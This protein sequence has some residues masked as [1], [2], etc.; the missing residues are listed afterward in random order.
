MKIILASGSP[1]RKELLKLIIPEFEVIVSGLDEK[2]DQKLSIQE[3]SKALA[4]IKAKEVFDRTEGDR[5]VIGSDTIV[6]KNEKIYGK[7]KSREDAKNML[8]ELIQGDS[9]HNIYTSLAIIVSKNGEIK[10]FNCVDEVK[11]FLKKM[12]DEEIEKWL[13]LNK[14]QGKAGAYG[15][16]DEFC[17]YVEKIEGNYTSV[18]GLPTHR[19]YD[20]LSKIRK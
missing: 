16:Q 10:E 7:A 14:W 12:T 19:V 18:V 1:R 2:V 9:V 4:H 20:I 6:S 17:I 3:Q 5:I 8:K 13:D 11:V 15:I